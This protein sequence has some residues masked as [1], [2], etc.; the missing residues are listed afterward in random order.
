MFNLNTKYKQKKSLNDSYNSVIKKLLK[1]HDKTKE[2]KI[3]I[4]YLC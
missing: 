3:N 4:A 1:E 2:L